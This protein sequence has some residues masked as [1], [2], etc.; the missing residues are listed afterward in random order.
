MRPQTARWESG[1]LGPHASTM[2]LAES[3][4]GLREL[5]IIVHHLSGGQ[6]PSVSRAP[7]D[8]ALPGERRTCALC[9]LLIAEGS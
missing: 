7:P 8:A 5:R 4:A 2:P 3:L 6:R 9:G 1:D